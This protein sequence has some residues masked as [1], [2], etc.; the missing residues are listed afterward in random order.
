MSPN[1]D[2]ER[3]FAQTRAIVDRD[4][5]RHI[6]GDA[7]VFNSLSQVLYHKY[8]GQ[9]RERILPEAV[10][11]TLRD[12]TAVKALWNHNADLVLGST[13]P[14]TL[15]LRKT[16]TAL[17]IDINPPSWADPQLETIERGD[18]DGMSFAFHVSEEGDVWD[19]ETS[20]GIPQRDIIDMNFSEVSIVAFPAYGATTVGVSQRSLDAFTEVR[21]ERMG[22]SVAWL[23]KVHE[24]RLAR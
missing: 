14:G 23:R 20:D 5:G 17:R 1:A 3:R 13:K 15:L 24:T 12:G 9:F 21:A 18:V 4:E 22:H 6:R 8:I 19:F 11:R 10:D 2:V 16:P 7:I